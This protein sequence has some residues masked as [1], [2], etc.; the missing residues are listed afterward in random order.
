MFLG[1]NGKI[2]LVVYVIDRFFLDSANAAETPFSI[3]IVCDVT[4]KEMSTARIVKSVI[5]GSDVF[6]IAKVMYEYAFIFLA[7]F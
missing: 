3:V 2:N 7:L 4:I 5:F 1:R 6:I